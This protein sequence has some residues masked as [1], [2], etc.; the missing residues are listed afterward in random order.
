MFLVIL[1][2]ADNETGLQYIGGNNC[3]AA[4]STHPDGN[5]YQITG[6]IDKRPV[7]PEK[8]KTRINNTIK[9]YKEITDEY[10]QNVGGHFKGYMMHFL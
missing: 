7:I 3:V 9:L 1:Y 2:K 8:V 4:P 6:N 10:S 5:K